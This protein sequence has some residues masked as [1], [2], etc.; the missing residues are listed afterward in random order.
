MGIGQREAA[1]TLGRSWWVPLSAADEWIHRFLVIY[2]FLLPFPF[3]GPDGRNIALYLLFGVWFFTR[4]RGVRLS[5]DQTQ[6]ALTFLL[7]LLMVSLAVARS[8]LPLSS[9]RELQR[10]PLNGLILF[11]CLAHGQGEV[12]RLRR[13]FM[14]FVCASALVAGYGIFGWLT[15]RAQM[16]GML[17]SVYGWKNALGYVLAVSVTI[18]VWRLLKARD[19]WSQ[20]GWATLGLMQLAVL[21]LSYTRAALL[22]VA[23]SSCILAI[24]FRRIRILLV[25]TVVLGA[26][27]ILGGDRIMTRYLSIAQPSTYLEGTLSGRRELWQGAVAMI[28]QRPF[29]GYGYGSPVF[30]H[31]A[32]AFADQ[33]GDLRPTS[34]S[35]AHN[36]FLEAA[37][38][39]GLLGLAAL[40]ALGGSV[41]WVLVKR[42]RS[43]ASPV[44]EPSRAVAWLLLA[45]YAAV[46]IISLTDYLVVGDGLGVYLW[47]L[48]ACT[49]ALAAQTD[50]DHR[51]VGGSVKC[52]TADAEGSA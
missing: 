52:G 6:L 41:A 31:V 4:E 33:T 16:D 22:A 19:V 35:H 37:V 10:G 47:V 42:C 20:A 51:R 12:T 32:R 36:L 28:R 24:A 25:G 13:Y 9:I 14:G 7:F 2:V 43:R 50:S 8:P 26:F 38:E 3:F 49:G 34:N 21:V 48:F 23:I 45:L 15:G 30:R 46:M 17:T 39:M 40:C 5:R 27:L 11:L 44:D 1:A 29:M 18:V